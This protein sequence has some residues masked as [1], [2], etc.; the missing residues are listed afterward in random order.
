MK[1]MR[2]FVVTALIL[3]SLLLPRLAFA[4]PSQAS[5]TVTLNWFTLQVTCPAE[6]MP[7]DALTVNVQG[8][9]NSPNVY[10]Q[11]L[12]ATIYYPDASG[13][14]QL[15]SQTLVSNSANVYAYYQEAPASSFSKNFT[16]IVPQNAP[17][18][19]LVA[20]FSETTQYNNYYSNYY[21]GPYPFSYWYYGNSLFYSFY[22]SYTTSIDQGISS[23]SYIRATTPE[24]VA[25]Q[26]EYQTL[27]QQLN[28]TK[29][30]N[31]QLQ[32]TITQQSALI[33]QLNQQLSSANATA[34]TYEAVAAVFIIIAAALAA[35]SI[36]TMRNKA[37]MKNESDRQGGK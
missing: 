15:T 13:L 16:L 6:V 1:L 36:Y 20:V 31:Q 25:L 11:N 5:Y 32:T 19:S 9:P 27:Q 34:Q 17:R 28:Q 26:S 18:T 10:L 14:H 37:K 23:L 7:G 33:S 21:Y 3:F 2:A 4:Q 30:Q 24:Y 8:T 12:T 22:P 29:T 35:F